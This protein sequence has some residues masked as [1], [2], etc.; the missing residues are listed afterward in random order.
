MEFLDSPSIQKIKEPQTVNCVMIEESWITPIIQYLK[1]SML[2][3]DK[4]KTRLLRLKA[5]LYTIYNDQ[6]YKRGFSI[7][8]LKCVDLEEGNHILQEIHEGIYGNHIGGQYLTHKV[9]R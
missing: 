5:T 9:L 8:L 2:S 7:P 1:D 4:R 3:E 6:L